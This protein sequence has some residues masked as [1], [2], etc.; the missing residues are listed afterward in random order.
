MD[1]TLLAFL[2]TWPLD[3]WVVVPLLLTAGV[4][5]RGWRIFRRRGSRRW[6]RFHLLAFLGSLL[7]LFLALASPIEAFAPLLLQ[8]HMLQHLLLMMVAPPLLWLGE[9]LLPL[10]RGLPAPI[11]QVWVGPLFH[12]PWLRCLTAW[13]TRPMTAWT[14]FV[15][16]TWIWHIPVVYDRALQFAGLHYLQHLCFFLTALLFW[17]PVVLPFP[18]RPVS[19]RWLLIPYLIG[20]DLQNTVLAALL[21]FS[22]RVLYPH[23]ETV[24]RLWGIAALQDQA[25]AG[26]LMWVPGSLAFLV[27]VVWIG[28]RLLYGSPLRARGVSE[29][30]ATTLA[31]ASGSDA[32]GRFALP[33]VADQKPRAGFMRLPVLGRF[34]RWRHARLSLQAV[35]AFLAV[36]VILD[37]LL[38]PPVAAMNLA[39]VLP[40]LHWR[41]LVVLGLLVGGNFFC[42]ACP[43]LLPRTIAR[44]FL[45]ARFRWPRWLRSK[46]PAI[47]LLVLFFWAYEVFALWD[48]PWLTAWIAVGYFLAALVIDGLFQGASFCKYV[49]PIGQFHFVQSLISPLQVAV[50]D[51]A[52]CQN[53]QT[54]DCIRG[55]DGIPGCELHLYQPRKTGNMDC[56]FCLDCIHACPHDNVGILVVVPGSDLLHDQV[57]SGVGQLGRRLDVAILVAVLTFAAFA[58]AAGMVAPVVEMQ[59]R[60]TAA[61]G[62][63]SPRWVI[64]A[65]LL[66]SMVVLPLVLVGSAA[67]LGRWWSRDCG[68]WSEVAARFSFALVPLGFGMWLA[69]YNFHFL[70]AP[71]SFIPVFQRTAADL[72]WTSFGEPAWVCACCLSVDSWLLRL[73]LL[74]LDV[75]LLGSLYLA[76]RIALER[77]PRR[78][79]ALRALAPW[80]TLLILLFAFGMWVLFQPM[81]MRGLME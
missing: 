22:S 28:S 58:N 65:G 72:G 44:K 16:S 5:I 1:P 70:S 8:V 19:S 51:P 30:A 18:G 64:T 50:R 25:V 56:T 43:F 47:G 60:L 62:L 52:A 53:C 33:L 37:G 7:A 4:Y 75:G 31:Y 42:M 73:E 17:W 32:H 23:Y 34:L 81:Q 40:W 77:R 63:S 9:P 39:G 48:S 2:K 6:E 21:T 15:A 12:L 14:L 54:R 46:W 41:G 35:L 79:Q 71:G 13:L 74:F 69:H 38:G 45:P 66:V 29:G 76:Y 57:R 3:P 78:P 10:L 55:R 59:D 26:V 67:V 49:C 68:G 61:L 36:A 20:A 24:P 80:A 11:R 27:P